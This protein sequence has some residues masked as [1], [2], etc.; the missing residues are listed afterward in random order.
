MRPFRNPDPGSAGGLDFGAMMCGVTRMADT[1]SK[2]PSPTGFKPHRDPQ[3][4]GAVSW[5]A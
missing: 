5:A 1:W 4:S 3:K 2:P